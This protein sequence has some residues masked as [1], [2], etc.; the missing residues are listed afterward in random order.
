[1]RLASGSLFTIL[2]LALAGCGGSEERDETPE[3]AAPPTAAAEP[4]GQVCENRIRGLAIRYPAGWHTDALRVGEACQAFHPEPFQIR[5]GTDCCP[6]ALEARPIRE[7]FERVLAGYLDERYYRLLA[8]EELEAAGRPAVRVEV[9]ATGEGL[10]ERGTRT[11]AY[12]ID[13]DGET[14]VVQTIAYPG[15]EQYEAWRTIAD[16]ATTTLR[17]DDD[18]AAAGRETVKVYFG[19]ASRQQ[20]ASSC[21]EVF[22]RERQ[23]L[24]PRTREE[25]LAAALERLLEGPTPQERADGYSSWFSSDTAGT[26]RAVRILPERVVR[27]DFDDFSR[28]LNGAN[29]SCGSAS[30][31]AALDATVRAAV[32]GARP[33]YSFHDDC[34]AFYEWLQ[35]AA[36][37]CHA[38]R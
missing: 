20:D 31:Y 29:T 1:M 30:L 27:V 38:T 22:A 3:D 15:N 10:Y 21:G 6:W 2:V 24:A 19:N 7:P 36:P 8:R 33:V 12:L 14:F 11:Y 23:I 28:L 16:E 37:A 26:L 34:A 17:L 25:R 35:A 5:D 13:R 32:P 9:E 4:A 18:L